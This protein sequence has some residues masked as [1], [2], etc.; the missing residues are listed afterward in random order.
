MS[1]GNRALWFLGLAG[2]LAGFY[3]FVILRLEFK[4]E[5]ALLS[6][7]TQ[8]GFVALADATVFAGARRLRGVAREM[9]NLAVAALVILTVA[10]ILD[11]YLYNVVRAELTTPWPS[12][13]LRFVWPAP[14][15]LML[16]P[17]GEREGP[18]VDW[19]RVLDYTQAAILAV[20]FYLY[21]YY[22]RPAW[23]TSGE[24]SLQEMWL[25]YAVRDGVIAASLLLRYG[26]GRKGPAREMRGQMGIFFCVASGANAC[27]AWNIQKYIAEYSWLD[28]A[29]GLQ[30]A[31]L[32]WFAVQWTAGKI[33]EERRRPTRSGVLIVSQV[34]PVALPL[35]VLLMGRQIVREQHAVAWLA[36]AASFACS[37]ARLVL[38]NRKREQATEALA[39]S[40]SLLQ[41]VTEGTPD[42]VY[43]KDLQGRYLMI[44]SAGARFFGKRAE[45]IIGKKDL[46][47]M[48]ME[49]GAQVREVDQRI[50][51]SGQAETMEQV[52]EAGGVTRI[53]FTAKS[54][55]RGADG[56]IAGVVGIS[57][58]ITERVKL[59]RRVQE[60]R[61]LEA[62][63]TLAGGVAHDFNN[64]ITVIR[65][66][67]EMLFPKVEEDEESL[68]AVRQIDESASRAAFLTSQLL[69][70]SQR[71]FIRPR[72]LSVN[73]VVQ[74]MVPVLEA[75]IGDKV[76]LEMR[77]NP[78]GGL[79][80]ADPHQIEQIVMNLAV[81]ARD[82]MEGGGQ[83]RIETSLAM[84][85]PQDDGARERTEQVVITV[86]DT[87]H[88]MNDETQT[89]VFEPFF[90]TKG[91]GR[92]TGMGL[93]TVYGI[94]QQNGGNVTVQS[95]VGQGTTFRVFLPRVK[96]EPETP[97]PLAV[98]ARQ[99]GGRET[100]LVVDDDHALRELASSV[101]AGHGY[102]ILRAET[103]ERALHLCA[104][105]DGAI[106]L[107]LTDVIMPGMN[108]KELAEKLY[109]V[110]PKLRFLF[111]SGYTGSAAI[112][113]GPL[114]NRAGFLSKPFSAEALCETVRGLLDS[115]RPQ[116]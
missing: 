47:L 82:A 35:V 114:A 58:E 59:E 13:V 11:V 94:V 23:V 108:G 100:I 4:D 76:R 5:A 43:V 8:L 98:P 61:K 21:F 2:L 56:K 25:L 116:L 93:A 111:M 69:A 38:T 53:F 40:H 39:G 54:V 64:L 89:R 72:V 109:A 1:L 97:T 49:T 77:L 48:S 103:A 105:R 27:I 115:Q 104:E 110:Y 70:F 96:E 84:K 113:H 83:L 51:Q 95:S 18:S 81:N 91:P 46:D 57:R 33:E 106:D 88:G 107:V 73:R 102:R 79:V 45:E 112:L 66:Y 63:G 24:K 26:L 78:R 16:L 44:N 62:V 31:V 12:D 41:A 52:I 29:W 32:G 9:A 60:A 15:L 7:L 28:L 37:S 10:Q 67:C 65:G 74:E 6:G 101:L 85:E 68:L 75:L 36:V 50:L 30:F 90:T 42:A 71:Q 22:V 14:F 87:G 3:L 80:K 99:R 20:T 19:L 92:G 55:Y 17:Q 34:V 86:A